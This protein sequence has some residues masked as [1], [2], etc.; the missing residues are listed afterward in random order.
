MTLLCLIRHARSTWNADGRVQG[1]A[2]PPLDDVGRAQAHALG[3]HL[4]HETF[5][6]L[7]CSPLARARETAAIVTGHMPAPPI[8]RF[9]DRLK[10]RDFGKWTGLTGSE[11]DA[12]VA[13]NPDQ[14]W[15]L[16]GPPGGEAR[17]QIVAR[18]EA[19]FSEIIAAHL[20]QKIAVVSH[21]GL[22]A[23]YMGHLLGVPLEKQTY[24]SF[25]NTALARVRIEPGRLTLLTL[26]D[27]RHLESVK[28]T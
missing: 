14:D 17:G 8:I 26:N 10:E 7:Y 9:D 25:H 16:L 11:V 5:D 12:A 3:K 1:Q 19:V 4:R 23:A 18:A 22:L 6:A 27:D 2:D 20:D 24:F 13:L 15:R 28:A 21:G